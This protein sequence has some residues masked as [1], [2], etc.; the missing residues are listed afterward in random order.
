M[1]ER[2]MTFN[3]RYCRAGMERVVP[4]SVRLAHLELLRGKSDEEQI[5]LKEKLAAEIEATCPY[6]PGMGPKQ[7]TD[8]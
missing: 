7:D 3:E 6:K 8:E 5:A 1:G 4:T 2:A